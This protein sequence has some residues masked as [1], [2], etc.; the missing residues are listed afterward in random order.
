MS[1]CRSTRDE[2][3]V[4]MHTNPQHN[5]SGIHGNV[6]RLLRAPANVFLKSPKVDDNTAIFKISFPSQISLS[7]SPFIHRFHVSNI[8]Y[9]TLCVS[10]VQGDVSGNRDQYASILPESL[11]AR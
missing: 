1:V 7:H 2:G 5:L 11:L 3:L 10:W 4:S 9:L 6:D 8:L